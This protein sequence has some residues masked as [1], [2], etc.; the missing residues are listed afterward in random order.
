MSLSD[1]AELFCE[2]KKGKKFIVEARMEHE[3]S[4]NLIILIDTL[5]IFSW[6]CDKIL[7]DFIKT[8]INFSIRKKKS[9]KIPGEVN[10]W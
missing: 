3:S 10:S 1:S 5:E 9:R 7:W 8:S 2:K 4:M 6:K